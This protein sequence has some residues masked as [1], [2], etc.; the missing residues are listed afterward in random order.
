MMIHKEQFTHL[1]EAYKKG[2][3]SPAGEEE[4]FALI[5]LPEYRRLLE[6]AVEG[7]LYADALPGPVLTTAETEQML[8]AIRLRNQA[9]TAGMNARGRVRQGWFRYA[10]AAAVLL[11][12]GMGYYLSVREK[13]PVEAS[14]PAAVY[15]DVPPGK[16]GAVLTLADGRSVTLDS[17]SDG[18]ITH[19]GG[20]RVMMENGRLTYI[21]QDDPSGTVMYNTMRTPNGRQFYLQLPD[22]TG[23][24]L[25]A[26]SSIT[27][28]VVFRGP[29]RTVSITG[30]VY[31][32][33][34]PRLLMPHAY[35]AG[36]TP[37]IVKIRSASGDPKG[38]VEV[39]GT[40]FNINAYDDESSEK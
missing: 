9:G 24:W 4:L 23:V 19:Q 38:E 16:N 36:K 26:G 33:V 13:G 35:T 15:K 17:I 30:E 37:F 12:V 28:P 34:A 39:L 21:T 3:I 18:L 11:L 6:N 29:E 40:H 25:N 2:I 7:S 20:T 14:Q 32:E 8:Q 27:Y 5:S 10:A 31:F 1:L 22:G